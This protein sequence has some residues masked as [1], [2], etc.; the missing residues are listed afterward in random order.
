VKNLIHLLIQGSDARKP[1][2]NDSEFRSEDSG[3]KE[4]SESSEEE[5]DKEDKNVVF[6]MWGH[7]NCKTR[8]QS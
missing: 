6:C 3:G 8:L 5:K 1:I 4:S 7:E 2:E